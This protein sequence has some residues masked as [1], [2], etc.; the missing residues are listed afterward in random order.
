M[1]DL[2][3]ADALRHTAFKEG[4]FDGFLIFNSANLA[5]F[6]GFS[7]ASALLIPKSGE[8][9]VYVYGVNYEHGEG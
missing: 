2:N 4:K 5:Y 9:V 6:T 3:R 1:S 7:G 8:S